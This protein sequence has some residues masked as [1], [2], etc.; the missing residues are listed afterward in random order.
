MIDLSWPFNWAFPH[1][2]SFTFMWSTVEETSIQ[3]YIVDS[4]HTFHGRAKM[5]PIPSLGQRDAASIWSWIVLSGEKKKCPGTKSPRWSTAAWNLWGNETKHN[6]TTTQNTVYPPS[7][8]HP[9]LSLENK[10]FCS[11]WMCIYY[12][13]SWVAA[14]WTNQNLE[15][16]F[17]YILILSLTR[18]RL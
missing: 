11:P 7:P 5:T 10:H 15:L 6:K 17:W 4:P 8:G 14:L 9:C 3:K 13:Q 2:A 12:I 16:Q 18:C 1:L